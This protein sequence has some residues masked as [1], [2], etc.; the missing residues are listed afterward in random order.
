M[1][2]EC[3][4][5]F[6]NSIVKAHKLRRKNEPRNQ[7]QRKVTICY[8]KKLKAFTHKI[9]TAHKYIFFVEKST[10]KLSDLTSRPMWDRNYHVYVT[11]LATISPPIWFWYRSPGPISQSSRKSKQHIITTIARKKQALKIFSN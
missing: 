10:W 8:G 2:S 5:T 7:A 1:S 3:V 4:V 9:V 11:E 6:F